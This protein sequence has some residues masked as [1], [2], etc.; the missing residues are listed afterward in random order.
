MHPDR[1]LSQLRGPD[2]DRRVAG[3]AG[4]GACRTGALL[5]VRRNGLV[6]VPPPADR[7][8]A[9]RPRRDRR[10]PPRPAPSR[11][12]PALRRVRDPRRQ[13]LSLRLPGGLGSHGRPDSLNTGETER[14]RTMTNNDVRQVIIIGGGPAGYTAAL[15]AAR[16]NL[17]PLVIEGFNWGGQLMITSDVENYPG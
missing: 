6:A 17:R 1:R 12:T 11:A 2:G 8:A 14:R 13:A 15:Y 7:G 3:R 5:H 16:A 9:D 4:V 10:P